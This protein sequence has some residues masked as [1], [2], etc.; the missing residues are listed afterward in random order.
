MVWVV[1]GCHSEGVDAPVDDKAARRLFVGV[2]PP[3]SVVRSLS[4]LPRPATPGVRW[5]DPTQWHLTLRFLPHAVPAH[6]AAALDRADLSSAVVTLGPHVTALGGHVIAIPADGLDDLAAVVVNV[7]RD[8]GP[9]DQR[10][11]L[12]HL[13]LA[14]TKTDSRCALVGQSFAA[15][16]VAAALELVASDTSGR[17]ARHRTLASWPLVQ[18]E[19]GTRR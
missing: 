2:R 7:T 4:A 8:L 1:I 11:F 17:G 5:V 18:P 19:D 10:P 12:G 6:V 9:V 16:F 14:R 3:P 13:T 15:S